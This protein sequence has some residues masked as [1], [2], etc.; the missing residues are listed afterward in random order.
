MKQLL[1]KCFYCLLTIGLF[2][3]C[4]KAAY[5]VV[6]HVNVKLTSSAFEAEQVNVTINSVQANYTDTSWVNLATN[7]Q[8]Y[9]LLDYQNNIDTSIARG[10]LPATSI[11]KKI[12]IV[13][14]VQNYI[15]LNGKLLPLVSSQ[16]P[17]IILEVNKKLNRN[18]ENVVVAFNPTLSITINENGL[19]QFNP[20]A[21]IK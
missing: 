19:Y 11:L 5:E 20:V 18:I 16:N 7:N 9:N 6:T 15:K 10:P 12:K 21:V 2:A 13:F 8:S 1:V 17:V 4:E 3:G 14:G